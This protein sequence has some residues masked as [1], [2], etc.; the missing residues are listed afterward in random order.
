MRRQ[1]PWTNTLGS[2]GPRRPGL[3]NRQGH[4][5]GRG[6]HIAG[7]VIE[8]I[9]ILVG[10]RVVDP[11]RALGHRTTGRGSD[12]GGDRGHP[13]TSREPRPALVAIAGFITAQRFVPRGRSW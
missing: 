5:V 4:T 1:N 8:P 11:A 13:R 3:A 10:V 6:H 7:V 12:D 9:E 2:P